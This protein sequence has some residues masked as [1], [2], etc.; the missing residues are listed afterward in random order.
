M[1]VLDD[2]SHEHHLEQPVRYLETVR[3]FLGEI[4]E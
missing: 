2:A 1:A 3:Q 4:E